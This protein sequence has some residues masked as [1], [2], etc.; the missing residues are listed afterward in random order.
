MIMIDW[1]LTGQVD[2]KA[3]RP[4]VI[5]R[6]DKCNKTRQ[7]T[8][9]VKS[10]LKEGIPWLCPQCAAN[11]KKLSK[12]T[13]Q[14]WQD[15]NYRNKI[16]ESSIKKW[17]EEEYKEKH[18]KAVRSEKSREKCSVAA[19]KAWK[20][21][22]YRNNHAVALAKQLTK[23]PNTELK[24]RS[25][26]DGLGIDYETNYVV[27]PYTFD[28]R[29]GKLLIEVNGN[30]WH[31]RPYVMRK[32]QAKCAY[33]STLDYELRTIWEHQLGDN[34]KIISLLKMWI[35]IDDDYRSICL[36]DVEF[37]LCDHDNMKLFMCNYHYLGSMGRKGVLISGH[38]DDEMVCGVVYAHPTRKESYSN[39]NITSRQVLELTRFCISPLVRCK[40][41]AS[42]ALSK[43]M[44]F[45]PADVR[46]L[47]SY[48][49]PGDGHSGTIYKASNWECVGDTYVSY[50]YVNNDGWKMHK[51][52]LYN[53][54]RSAHMSE[55]EFAVK[56][57]YK[58]I[59]LPPL[60]K[61]IYKFKEK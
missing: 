10:K 47:I 3:Y 42:R 60:R 58:R 43:S 51:K 24:V 59:Y 48:A 15:N 28:I 35:G 17:N 61:Y 36:K 30:W 33:I 20:D 14:S 50:F 52:T 40:N 12:K 25:I 29:I 31:T 34:D 53:Q 44:K 23:T 56:F 22:N 7:Y 8:I 49:S 37:K 21:I 19:K 4:K 13:K 16:T 45:I 6:C 5:I 32:D 41:L 39:Y 46:M 1:N 27:G 54:A 2:L 55:N 18:K 26:L 9:R 57:G 38:L 11:N